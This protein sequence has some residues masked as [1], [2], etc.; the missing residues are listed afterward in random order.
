MLDFS[1]NGMAGSLDVA[2]VA[3]RMLM[4]RSKLLSLAPNIHIWFAYKRR[5]FT[6]NFLGFLSSFCLTIVDLGEL[7]SSCFPHMILASLLGILRRRCRS[8]ISINMFLI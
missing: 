5:F 1:V 6:N 8:T 7:A 4:L 3:A 2:P